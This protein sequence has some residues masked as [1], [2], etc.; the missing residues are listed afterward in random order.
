MKSR[1]FFLLLILNL[2]FL[3]SFSQT[4]DNK[5]KSLLEKEINIF[6]S[7]SDLK[8]ASVSFYAIDLK[9]GEVIAQI[10]PDLLLSPASTMKIFTTAAA[11]E[12]FGPDYHF[13][14]Q[15]EYS[16]KILKDSSLQ[17]NIYLK[18]GGDPV[19]YSHLFNSN[20]SNPDF[21]SKA[22]VEIKGKGINKIKGSVIGDASYYEDNW[23][24]PTWIMADVANYYG[25]SPFALSFMDNEYK[26][27]FQTGSNSGDSTTIVKI[28]PEIPE[29]K[30][31]NRVKSLDVND[32][33]SVIF[34]GP[35]ENLR[36]ITGCLPLQKNN[37]E[38]K[39]SIPDP[40][41]L[42][43]MILQKV[44]FQNGI[45]V[46]D[47]AK[48]LNGMS[49]LKNDTNIRFPLIS[50]K[51]PSLK[52]I[53]Y[54]TNIKSVNL[55]A[56][57]L[58]RQ[59]G[60]KEKGKATNQTGIDAI[61]DFWKPYTKK[62]MMF[63]GSGLSRFNAVSAKQLVSVLSYMKKQS[64]NFEYFYNSL[65]VASRSGSLSGMFTGSFAENNLRAKSGY[66]TGV[67]SYAGYVKIKSSKEIAFAVIINNYSSSPSRVK[68]QIEQ[69]LI[70]L[71]EL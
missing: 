48:S 5:G 15:I 9:T 7:D 11:L 13:T 20:Y 52:D 70:K 53:I 12:I 56:E 40:P 10:N 1:S 6:L 44:L 43:A 42:A 23:V 62:I 8:N 69:L 67:R 71:S 16:G 41:L 31:E 35:F 59:I 39:G 50:I 37:Y 32:D 63:D 18:G 22:A 14:T 21:F 27:H 45:T 26:V 57:H 3:F 30:L 38:V 58:L 66:M 2:F 19:F 54:Y 49:L 34:G 47:S 61:N 55:Y 46:T 51:S 28:D 17:G 64:K 36:I 29:M 60:L 4:N 68:S 25:A 33:Q 65:P 24:P